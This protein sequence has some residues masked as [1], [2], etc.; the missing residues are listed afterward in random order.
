MTGRAWAYVVVGSWMC[1]LVISCSGCAV[2][3]EAKCNGKQR[4]IRDGGVWVCS[5]FYQA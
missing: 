4:L 5:T 3:E 1:L 2:V